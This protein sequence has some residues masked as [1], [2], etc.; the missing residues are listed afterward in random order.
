MK[1]KLTLGGIGVFLAAIALAGGMQRAETPTQW[2]MNATVIEACSCPMFCQCY[3]NPEPAAHGHGGPEGSKHFCKFNL[4]YRVNEG[5][6]GDVELDGVKFWIAGDLGGDFSE[7]KMDWAVVTF[8]RAMTDVQRE[9]MAAILARLFPVEWNS[10]TTSEGKIDWVPG[11]DEA[12]AKLDG[13]KTAEVHLKRF[14]GMTSDP[15]VIKN[16]KYWGAQHN[17]GFVLMPNV[18]EAWRGDDR[19]FEF[20]GRNGFM[21]TFDIDSESTS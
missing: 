6:F 9:A 15:V 12:W 11:K 20:K 16:L 7:G 17:D 10:F 8:D 14:E 5:N 3:F 1:T 19:S 18:V 2:S 21:I 13:G 4:A